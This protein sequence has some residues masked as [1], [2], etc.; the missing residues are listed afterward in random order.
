MDFN[1]N[2]KSRNKPEGVE[3]VLNFIKRHNQSLNELISDFKDEHLNKIKKIDGY[4]I[5]TQKS[6]HCF[7]CKKDLTNNHNGFDNFFKHLQS[8]KLANYYKRLNL[9]SINQNLNHGKCLPCHNFIETLI[10]KNDIIEHFNENKDK[11]ILQNEH[12]CF[13]CKK[14]IKF[15]YKAHKN[16]CPVYKILLLNNP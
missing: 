7:C 9:N 8:C 16:A 15:N 12:E 1:E 4:E 13:Y 5:E 10:Q 2:L 6:V 11:D 14:Y 3:N